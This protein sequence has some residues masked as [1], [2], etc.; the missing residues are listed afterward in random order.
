MDNVLF[1]AFVKGFLEVVGSEMTPGK[2]S[3]WLFRQS[4]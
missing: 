1:E 4:L 3:I 2:L